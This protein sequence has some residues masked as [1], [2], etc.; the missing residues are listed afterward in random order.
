M[1]ALH[2]TLN[3]IPQLTVGQIST[4]EGFH[5]ILLT[6]QTQFNTSKSVQNVFHRLKRKKFETQS[7]GEPPWF[8]WGSMWG[9][10]SDFIEYCFLGL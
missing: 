1:Y 9:Q 2:K 3:I 5:T 7:R 8:K 10:V 4:L 6:H